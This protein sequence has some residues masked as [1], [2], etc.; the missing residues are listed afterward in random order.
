MTVKHPWSSLLLCS[1]CLLASATSATAQAA[2][3]E[4]LS[5]EQG[6]APEQPTPEPALSPEQGAAPEQALAPANAAAPAQE[7]EIEAASADAPPE[8][9]LSEGAPAAAP[10]D[11]EQGSEARPPEKKIQIPVDIGDRHSITYTSLLAP[12]IN[13][14]GLEE[15][16]WI[17]YQY[18]LYDK[19]KALLKGSNIGVFFR[20]V[21]SPAIALVGATLQIQP[22][23]VFRLRATY[24]YVAY[25][26]TFQYMQSF[27][28]P[29]DDFSE[30]NLDILADEGK[31]YVSTGHQ[32]ELEALVQA[33][34]KGLALRSTTTV[35]YNSLNLRGDDD[36]FYAIRID[37]LVPNKGWV[38]YNDTDLLWIHDFENARNSSLMTGARAT[39][40]M[41]FYPDRVYEP[42]DVI[43][44]PN[45]PQFRLGPEI[46]YIFYDRP[47]KHPRFNRPTLLVL[48]Q[49]NIKH[50]WRTGRDVSAGLP[51][52]VMAFV[53]TGQL[54]GKN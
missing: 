30:T 49:W 31:N 42:G 3:E 14:L 23:A 26:S 10:S 50:R 53:F 24:S 8:P 28:S 37:A 33:R 44:N 43:D 25:F 39:T 17:G 13:P 41:P 16:L 19:S 45:G 6:A 9:A 52:I 18:R 40:V 12:R 21:V 22:A 2:P 27:Q 51:T 5:P 47:D 7:Q 38:L 35:H 48:P 20:P 32:I 4:P 11:P 34:Y 46:G 29:Y 1:F 54:W 15:R 36:L